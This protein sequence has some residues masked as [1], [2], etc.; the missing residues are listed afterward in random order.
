M[1]RDLIF[2]Y[3]QSK[4]LHPKNPKKKV[5]ETVK[6]VQLSKISI[7][8]INRFDHISCFSPNINL[9][10]TFSWDEE[11]QK[12]AAIF[13]ITDY[14]DYGF[15]QTQVLNW[16]YPYL[17]EIDIKYIN[18]KSIYNSITTIPQNIISNI[19]VA[20]SARNIGIEF[21]ADIDDNTLHFNSTIIP[22]SI[23]PTNIKTKLKPWLLT[24]QKMHSF[25]ES[26]YKFLSDVN[27]LLSWIKSEFNL[28]FDYTVDGGS[29]FRELKCLKLTSMDFDA[30]YAEYHQIKQYG[31]SYRE[32]QD[33]F[34]VLL[35]LFNSK[36]SQMIYTLKG[37]KIFLNYNMVYVKFLIFN[38]K[39]SSSSD[40]EFALIW[41]L[42]KHSGQ[43]ETLHG[44]IEKTQLTYE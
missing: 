43:L 22:S 10:A 26:N 38:F 2:G 6:R 18:I 44:C 42:I 8:N 12:V 29:Q 36:K 16:C 41:S 30:V 35:T 27:S 24:T 32:C 23:S 13:M 33:D 28:M 4:A 3:I 21:A 7:D 25:I 20:F 5:T 37:I 31:D 19:Q 17:R 34:K 14:S 15:F 1:S 9:Y 40:N 39:L 11:L